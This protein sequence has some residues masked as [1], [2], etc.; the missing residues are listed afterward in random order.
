MICPVCGSENLQ[1]VD[2]CENC[3]A[4][5]RTSDI[6]HPGN[7]LE[8][9]LVRERLRVLHP[10]Q[11]VTVEP[12]TPIAEVLARMRDE[13]VEA[14]LVV[15][16]GQL[17]GIFTERDALM[18]LA[19]RALDGVTVGEVMTRDPVVLRA[20]DSLAVAIHKMAVGGFRHIPLVEGTA[21]VRL[22]SSSDLFAHI[23]RIL[24]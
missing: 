13:R 23:G 5:L 3:G 6:P 1:G 21:P 11:P 16:R 4:D 17:V 12:G 8:A 22:V 14:V 9:R 24:G 20:E 15:D 7:E 18:K 19:T 2:E 10:R